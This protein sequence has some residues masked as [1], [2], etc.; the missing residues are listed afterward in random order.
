MQKQYY[1]LRAY[2][3]AYKGGG[4][5]SPQEQYV[6]INNLSVFVGNSKLAFFIRKRGI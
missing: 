6:N 2:A 5:S 1:N 3:S 4:E